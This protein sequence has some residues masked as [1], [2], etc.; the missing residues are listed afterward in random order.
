M[1]KKSLIKGAATL[2]FANLISRFIGFFYRIYMSNTIGP[3]GM[4]LYQLIMPIYML[5]WSISASGFTTTISKLTAQETA[6]GN[7][8]NAR[9]ILY[10]SLFLC[11]TVSIILSLAVFNFA[12]IISKN[13]LCDERTFIS[14]KILSICIPFMSCGSCIRGYFF[15]I[16]ETSVP[17][18]SQVIEQVVRVASV[19]II[20]HIFAPLR[21]SFACAAAIV[22]VALGE[23]ISFLCV[24]LM[25]KT[26]S[27]KRTTA[28]P[29]SISQ[30]VNMIL[31]MAMPLTL[32]RVI[33][34]LLSTAENILIPIRLKLYGQTGTFALSTY[35][36]LTGMAMP[37]IQLPSSLLTAVSVALVPAI[38]EASAL[39]NE[40]SIKLTASKSIMYTFITGIGTSFVFAVFSKEICLAIYSQQSLGSLLLRLSPVCPFLYL[41]ITLTGLLN[42]LGEHFFVFRNN[43]ISSVVN[44]AFIYFLV[45]F[46]G[47]DAFIFGWFVSLFIICIL[48]LK[49]VID[50]TK[51]KPNLATWFFKPILAVSASGLIIRYLWIISPQGKLLA[52]LSAASMILLYLVFLILLDCV[53]K[54]DIIQ[55]FKK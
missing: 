1:S 15:G 21:L 53:D 25:F 9:K 10:C 11:G 35:G 47:T 4:G 22:G 37:L 13:I 42:G 12:G 27:K 6:K 46:F 19:F 32:N 7:A 36:K 39:S 20:F 51:I 34:S 41:H 55:V 31:S 28:N 40:K 2:T 14:L 17:A 29:I 33:S 44:I 26:K 45:P 5:T 23:I 24:F 3:E 50:L 49:K 48:S 16:Q 43:I 52:V 54:D 38:S 18:L 8:R 30:S